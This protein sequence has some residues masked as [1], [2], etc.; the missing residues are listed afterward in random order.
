MIRRRLTRVLLSAAIAATVAAPLDVAGPHVARAA[1]STSSVKAGTKEVLVNGS[2]F[3]GKGYM[4]WPYKIGTTLGAGTWADPT[5]CENDAQLLQGAGATLMRVSWDENAPAFL[6]QYQQCA[7]SFYNHG[8][9]FL[10]LI[11]PPEASAAL[12]NME[13]DP[14]GFIATYEPWIQQAVND[15]KDWPATY[16]YSI[17]NELDG[18]IN[19]TCSAATPVWLGTAG[20]AKG[21]ADP[22]IAYTKSLD[23][24][25]IVGTDVGGCS[26][27]QLSTTNVP[28]LDFWGIHPY[29]QSHDPG[30]GTS[31]Y[32]TELSTPGTVEYTS[33][34]AL[35]DEMGTDRYNCNGGGAANG[36][37]C[38]YATSGEDQ[39]F[40][41][42]WD[43]QIWNNIAAALA[44][45]T[46]PSYSTFGGTF[47]MYSDL[48]WYSLA[49]FNPATPEFHDV[50]GS[51]SS[52]LGFGD[53][54]E[55][56]EW[57]G[58]TMATP[59]SRRRATSLT[60]DGLAALWSSNPQPTVS[61]V[62]ISFAPSIASPSCSATV[63]FNTAV[64][65]DTEILVSSDLRV[66]DSTGIYVI[67]DN[68]QYGPAGGDGTQATTHTN[69]PVVWNFVSGQR[70]F[71]II[72][73]T[74]TAGMSAT[75]SPIL[76][77]A[78]C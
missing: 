25:H 12:T 59:D 37:I 77:T 32:F 48:W 21:V 66:L 50:Y 47:F 39:S 58:V 9:G 54:V 73:S 46:N 57:W 74:T 10:W 62:A 19:G 17:G 53:G 76:V 70:Y 20:G 55:N 7:Q 28:S 26:D 31:N 5:E 49:G 33:K 75:T 63:S 41:R 44:T 29:F 51:S 8:I 36:I 16:M 22:L 27:A 3:T 4:Y 18:S 71:V 14:Q 60:F 69:V 1:G 2:V 68:T 43:V 45:D 38:A 67:Q 11:Q 40:Q 56:F 23:S 30:T 24:T 52:P 61:N 42:D 65:G 78:S 15:V 13:N 64:A 35:V 34:P 6:S 72:R